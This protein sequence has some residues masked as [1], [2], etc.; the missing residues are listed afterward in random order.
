MQLI[1]SVIYTRANKLHQ[2]NLPAMSLHCSTGIILRSNRAHWGLGP[3]GGVLWEIHWARGEF[4]SFLPNKNT[5]LEDLFY[6]SGLYVCRAARHRIQFYKQ[7]T[8]GIEK[9]Q[10]SWLNNPISSVHRQNSKLP[11]RPELLLPSA[12][13]T[14]LQNQRLAL[15]I[16]LISAQLMCAFWIF[17][18]VSWKHKRFTAPLQK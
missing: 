3:C 5:L 4:L 12:C 6:V 8:P 7:T 14:F 13:H 17:L 16:F 15:N 1:R 10:V 11:Q 2:L 9:Q 18:H